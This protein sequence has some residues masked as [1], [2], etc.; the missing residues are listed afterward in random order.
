M[1]FRTQSSAS[2][3]VMNVRSLPGWTAAISDTASGSDAFPELIACAVVMI[4]LC[5]ICR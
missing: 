1:T 2:I 4:P 5:S 3:A